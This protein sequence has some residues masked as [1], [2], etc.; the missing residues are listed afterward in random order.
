MCTVFRDSKLLWIP[1]QGAV[2]QR[3]N[4][5]PLVSKLHVLYCAK[6]KGPLGSALVF[7]VSLG[8]ILLPNKL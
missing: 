3:Y 7:C 1:A 8:I 5:F 6:C 2:S 4:F